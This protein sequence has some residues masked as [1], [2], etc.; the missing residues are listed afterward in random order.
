MR[1][2][3]TSAMN[4]R[5]LVFMTEIRIG[6]SSAVGDFTVRR[7]RDVWSLHHA[8]TL[9][10]SS[11]DACGEAIQSG[12]CVTLG[13]MT[14]SISPQDCYSDSKLTERGQRKVDVITHI[15]RMVSK[16]NFFHAALIRLSFP[17]T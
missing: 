3:Y 13:L 15:G 11:S 14:E 12:P 7:T 4:P 5:P 8:V 2:A 1:N 9:L 10:L 6:T 16:E 17:R